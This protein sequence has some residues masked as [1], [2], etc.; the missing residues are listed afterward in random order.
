[1]HT[2]VLIL[3]H[4]IQ[5]LG[6]PFSWSTGSVKQ[7]ICRSIPSSNYTTLLTVASYNNVVGT[8]IKNFKNRTIL[9][10]VK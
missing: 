6:L 1:M 8:T 3:D 7:K 9:M 5:S 4:V 2:S 10:M